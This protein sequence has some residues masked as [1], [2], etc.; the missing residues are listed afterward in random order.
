M[1]VSRIYYCPAILWIVCFISCKADSACI[2]E[3]KKAKT[4]IVSI[5]GPEHINVGEQATITI[6][7]FN[8]TGLCVKEATADINNIGF[9]TLLV[10]AALNYTN[11][12][13]T[14]DCDC[15]TDSIIY[16]LIYFKPLNAGTYRI[17]TKIDSTVSSVGPGNAA[18]YTI[19]A[20]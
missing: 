7:A 4:N 3:V 13:A 17:V 15:K 11:D 18:D 9:D 6:G 8:N 12:A 5:S 10:T 2:T 1:K 20:E 19:N 14:E 16:T